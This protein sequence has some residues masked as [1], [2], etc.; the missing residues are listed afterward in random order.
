M[1]GQPEDDIS[2]GFWSFHFNEDD[3]Y[4]WQDVAFKSQQQNS[5]LPPK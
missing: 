4:K 5:E 2:W 3:A 1:L